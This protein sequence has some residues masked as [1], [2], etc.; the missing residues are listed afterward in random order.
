M[1]FFTDPASLRNLVIVGLS[2]SEVVQQE[3]FFSTL[4]M[5]CS[6]CFGVGRSVASSLLGLCGNGAVHHLTEIS[7]E[8]SSGHYNAL[9]AA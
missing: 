3:A 8:N 4:E 5:L 1:L 7:A 2:Q 6:V 9:P